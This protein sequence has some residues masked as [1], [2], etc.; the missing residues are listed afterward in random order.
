MTYVAFGCE[1][2]LIVVFAFSAETKLTG[3]G[4]FA[5]F[6]LATAR[7]VP[8]FR[9]LAGP[10]SVAV[11]GVEVTT[12]VL[13]AVPATARVGLVLALALL[14]A[15]TVAV[16]AAL[17]RGETASCNCFGRSTT[18]MGARH[19]VRNALLLA[20]A[21]IGLL[22]GRGGAEV[23]G[24][25]LAGASAVVLAVLVLNLDALT[26]LFATTPVPERTTS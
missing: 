21:G 5:E 12:A 26:D 6:R 20:V 10:L 14:G 16:A 7:L 19:L 1:C 9:G 11:V 24:L 2:L 17:R 18:P 22:G 25:A 8:A 23:P 13:L 15:F 3:R 4:A